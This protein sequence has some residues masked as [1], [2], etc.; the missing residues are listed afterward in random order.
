MFARK[1]ISHDSVPSA[2]AKAERYRLLNEP[3]EAES[4]CRDILEI[5]PNHQIALTNL[6][7]AL[8]D[9]IS[10]DPLAFGD[11]LATVGRLQAPYDRAYYSGIVWER[12]AK[13]R[14]RSGHGAQQSAYD[15]LIKALGF[16]EEAERLRPAGNDDAVLRWNACVRYLARYKELRPR[17]EEAAAAIASE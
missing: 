10:D 4:I 2:L 13:S 5:D 3:T 8:T 17:N 14:H 9:Q 1:P 7:L 6:V 15:W 16:F 12:R 11:A